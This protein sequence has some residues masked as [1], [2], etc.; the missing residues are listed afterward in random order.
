MVVKSGQGEK[1]WGESHVNVDIDWRLVPDARPLSIAQQIAELISQSI[2]LGEYRPGQRIPEQSIADL[3]QVSRGPVREALRLLEREGVIEILPRRGAQVTLL[4]VKEVTDIFNI[5]AGLIGL[6][7]RLFIENIN[8]EHISQLKSRVAQLA[9]IC[10]D[11]DATE[12]YLSISFGL[13]LYVGRS[14]DN[15]QLYEMIRSLSRQTVRYTALGLASPARRQRSAKI[16]RILLKAV[17]KGDGDAAESACRTLVEESRD[18]AINQLNTAPAS[19]EDAA[20]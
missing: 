18:A 8:P 7:V 15:E 14:C 4:T 5:R 2:L 19:H 9:E 13:S 12:E 20:V 1:A 10:S 3:Y 11:P 6:S 17:Q 16:W